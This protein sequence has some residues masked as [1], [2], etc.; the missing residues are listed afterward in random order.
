VFKFLNDLLKLENEYKDHL[1]AARLIRGLSDFK[2]TME[3]QQ[4]Q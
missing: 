1:S 4:I 3:I 2:R